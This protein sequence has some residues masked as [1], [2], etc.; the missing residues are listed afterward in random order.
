MKKFK[1]GVYFLPTYNEI[2]IVAQNGNVLFIK[3][4]EKYEDW[5]S[6]FHLNS[7]IKEKPVYLGSE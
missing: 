6:W 5:T 2:V 3:D 7:F 4:S 1:R